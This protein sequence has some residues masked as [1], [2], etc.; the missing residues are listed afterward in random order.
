MTLLGKISF[1]NVYL[2][3]VTH[4]VAYTVIA[5]KYLMNEWMIKHLGFGIKFL[6]QENILFVNMKTGY[7]LTISKN[8]SL[9]KFTCIM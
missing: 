4:K 1:H 6:T 7:K 3:F 2:D 5:N 9:L 8:H